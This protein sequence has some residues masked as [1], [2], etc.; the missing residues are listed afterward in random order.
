MTT[1]NAL[2]F[3]HKEAARCRD[4]D[5]CEAFCLLLPAL[6]RILDLEPME[7]VEAAA[8]KFEFRQKLQGLPFQDETDRQAH[9]HAA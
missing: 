8:F 7:E 2:R 1:E 4:R 9:R 6:I 5:A 3:L